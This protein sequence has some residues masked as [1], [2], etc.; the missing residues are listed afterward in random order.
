MDEQRLS[1]FA[2]S[3]PRLLGFGLPVGVAV[4]I[5]LAEGGFGAGWGNVLAAGI[6]AIS[7]WLGMRLV[8][9]FLGSLP[10]DIAPR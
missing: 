6:L 10:R 4:L 2:A 9:S 7:L 5:F 3:H 8:L 1:A